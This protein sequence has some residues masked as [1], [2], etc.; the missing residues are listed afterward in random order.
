M[1][2]APERTTVTS[3]TDLVE[4]VPSLLGYH[5][6]DSLVLL[7]IR[8]G[9]VQLTARTDL[10]DAPPARALAPAWHRLPG[11]YF[12]VIAFSAD[13]GCAWWGLDDVDL[14]LPGDAERILVHADGERWYEHPDDEGTPYDAL[15]G[16][17]L[18]EAAYAGRPIRGSREELYALVEPNRTPAE[19]TA[20]LDRVAARAEGLSDIL[21]EARALLA[22][23]DDA[24]GDLEI[25]DATV[26]CLA[27]HDPCF[28]DE[29]LLSTT[30][31]NAAPRVSLWLQVVGCGVP[32]CVGGALAAA[33][34][35]AWL[36]GDGALQSVCLEAMDDRPGPAEWARFL[37]AVNLG[38]VP[39]AEWD[40]L[41]AELRRAR[42]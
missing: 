28:L 33:A 16:V 38:A 19:V 25:D 42:A 23:H 27:S 11:A 36:N 1:T 24:P 20:S 37:Q 2:E 34:L 41:A 21:G 12:V 14:A 10:F 3:L 22:A 7:A 5:P 30:R 18:A 6:H 32:N 35:A 13:A 4:V 26:L 39:P 15:G 9:M 31:A 29:A 8:D 17:L 40:S